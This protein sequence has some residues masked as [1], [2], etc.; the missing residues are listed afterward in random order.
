[1]KKLVK[2][3]TFVLVLFM[4][5]KKVYAAEK[6]VQGDY[7]PAYVNKSKVGTTRYMQMGFLKLS[8]S[9]SYVYCLEPFKELNF[10]AKYNR[11][12]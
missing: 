10:N 5:T 6:I 12:I 4:T 2:I 9:G 11:F 3:L 1:M 8:S 7:I